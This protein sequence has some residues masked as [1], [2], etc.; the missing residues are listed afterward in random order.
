MGGTGTMLPPRDVLLVILS[1]C[2]GYTAERLR[3][4]IS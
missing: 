4:V 3:M 2:Y 1:V